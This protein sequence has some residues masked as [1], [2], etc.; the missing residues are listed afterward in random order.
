MNRQNTL[1]SLILIGGLL[2]PV[3]GSALRV[4][5]PPPQTAG[6]QSLLNWAD[7][8]R[9]ISFNDHRYNA[10]CHTYAQVAVRQANLRVNKQCTNSIRTPNANLRNRWSRNYGVH[11]N[12]CRT[13]SAHASKLESGRRE[14]GLRNCYINR[15]RQP[16]RAQIH[17]ACKANDTMHK[18]AARGDFN[19]VQKCLNAGVS[20][21]IREG[22]RWTPL[23]SASSKG[24]LQIV[25]MLVR[26][27]AG[28][29]ARDVNNRTP[30]DLAK[31][32]GRVNTDNFL[33]WKG[34]LLS[35]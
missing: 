21:N 5:P 15:P 34:G 29:N 17:R 22:N 4:A 33:R 11:R 7:Q 10:Y 8:L 18:K 32:S 20:P 2:I 14:G 9:G 3:T 12:W 30:R 26:R 27:G 13:V 6:Y 19:Y 24:R 25:Q 28:V 31:L 1:M 23:H 35:R 16:T